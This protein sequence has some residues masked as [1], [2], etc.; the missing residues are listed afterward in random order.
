M[1]RFMAIAKAKTVH[2]PGLFDG[3][4][5]A[6]IADGVAR[7][8]S[9]GGEVLRERADRAV[10]DLPDGLVF[11]GFSFGG[12]A[13]RLAQTRSDAPTTLT[14]G[15]TLVCEEPGRSSRARGSPATHSSATSGA[16]RFCTESTAS[17]PSRGFMGGK[18]MVASRPSRMM[19]AALSVVIRAAV[20][21]ADS[22]AAWAG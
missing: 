1:G 11:V 14:P 6:T 13:R 7:T 20:T 16:E 15:Y 21:M 17:S 9:I 8:Q 18:A 4:R 10:A 12:T 5:P 3:E 2:T 22:A 19:A